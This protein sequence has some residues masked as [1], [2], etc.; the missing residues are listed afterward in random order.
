MLTMQYINNKYLQLFKKMKCNVAPQ[1]STSNIISEMR[2][3]L[4]TEIIINPDNK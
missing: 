1:H 4:V 3:I 2:T